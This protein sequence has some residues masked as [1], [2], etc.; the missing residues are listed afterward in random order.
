MQAPETKMGTGD[1]V[2]VAFDDFMRA[3]EAFKETNDERLAQIENQVTA[4]VVTDDKL[5]RINAAMDEQKRHLDALLL[6]QARPALG[7]SGIASA[8][9]MEHKTG[10]HAYLR[11][12]DTSGLKRLE[13]KAMSVSSDPD[14][15]S[16]V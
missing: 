16:M 3:F 8:A 13:E 11:G 4:D 7:K 1:D 5:G 15:G 2:A 6:K 12:G 10:F 9:Q 14:G